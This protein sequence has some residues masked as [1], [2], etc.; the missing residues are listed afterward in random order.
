MNT[1][2]NPKSRFSPFFLRLIGPALLAASAMSLSP[3][4]ALAGT[5]NN[6]CMRDVAGFALGCTSNDVRVAGVATNPDGTPKLVILD[7]GCKF[8]GDTVDFTATF[9]VVLTAQAR[10]DIGIYFAV[11]GDPNGDGALTGSCSV[12]TLDSANTSNF[13]NLDPA[14]D[15]C[16]DIDAAHNP[17]KP[18]VTLRNVACVDKNGDRKLDFPNCVSWRQPGSN[19]VCTVPTDA[20]PGSPSKCKCDTGFSLPIDVPPATI[21]VKKTANTSTV[22]EPGGAVTY[23]V[24]VH[25]TGVDPNNPFTL[26]SLIDS[27]FGNLSGKG[28]CSVPQTIA[29][30]GTYTCIFT[31]TV[32]GNAGYVHTNVVEAKGVDSRS[33]AASGKDD[34]TVNVLG[35]SPTMQVTKI[36]NPTQ[37]LEPGASVSYTVSVKNTSV[38]SDPLTLNGLSDDKFG[39][40]SGKGT[41]SVPQTIQPGG[42][43]SCTFSATVSGNAGYVHTNTVTVNAVDDDGANVSGSASATVNVLNVPSSITVTKTPTPAAVYEPGG[44]VSYAVAIKNNSTVDV[45][46]ISSLT[47]DKFGN[48][49]GKGNC[50]VPQAI[51]P[52]GTYSCTFSATLSGNAG[53]SHVNTVTASGLDDDNDPVRDSGSATVNFLDVLPAATLTKTAKSV[54]AT[55][56]IKVTN[57]KSAENVYL[58]SLAD[59]RFGDLTTVHGGIT[60]TTCRVPQ[61][62]LPMGQ[63]GDSYTCTFKANVTSSPHTNTATGHVSDDEANE[64]TPTPSD[65]ATVTFQ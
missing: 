58:T 34:E 35:V 57:D 60:E 15:S 64:V 23:T 62:L 24:S 1:A 50:A 21:E 49:S 63:T 40:L 65:S 42:T 17:L 46:T 33:N 47:D 59:D 30:G 38:S 56:E 16:G 19:G 29:A 18:T 13:I 5:I 9:D 36:A 6:G 22:N 8:P 14:P 26:Q 28:T 61:T 3:L 11:D 44:T 32:S 51:N 4:S 39:N 20:F 10:Y 54:L 7:D 27:K 37:V 2:A 53:D 52:G 41:C 25:N 43:Y 48:L 12:T 45:V 55:Y 31:A